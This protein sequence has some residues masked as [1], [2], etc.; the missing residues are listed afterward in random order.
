MNDQLTVKDQL[1]NLQ[2]AYSNAAVSHFESCSLA[3][4][5]GDSVLEE[6]R[7]AEELTDT[8]S[9]LTS[10]DL[11]RAFL[12]GAKRVVDARKNQD[13]PLVP[14]LRP[15]IKR[16]LAALPIPRGAL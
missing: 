7:T 1:T 9:V 13:N 2:E 8:L 4:S 15:V 14:V 6:F 10:P 5:R 11:K 3:R 16:E 12:D